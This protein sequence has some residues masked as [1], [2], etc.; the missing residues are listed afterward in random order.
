MLRIEDPPMHLHAVPFI[1][2]VVK[3]CP[4]SI[5]IFCIVVSYFGGHILVSCFLIFMPELC[6]KNQIFEN[7][8]KVC[9]KNVL[10]HIV[11]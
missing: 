5:L 7:I 4:V 8:K 6:K 1:R 11:S 10:S 9:K 3:I 2:N